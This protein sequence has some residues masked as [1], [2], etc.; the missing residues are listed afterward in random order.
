MEDK[1][2]SQEELLKLAEQAYEQTKEEELLS[3]VP[4]QE[5]PEEKEDEPSASANEPCTSEKPD[6][7]EPILSTNWLVSG[8]AMG[9]ILGAV[10]GFVLKAVPSFLLLGVITGTLVG[11]LLDK[12]KDKKNA[13][14]KETQKNDPS[15][16]EE[17]NHTTEENDHD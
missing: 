17:E 10:L 1:Q 11:L 15:I 9:L 14:F 6:D 4:T 3:S 13:A 5:Q 12:G 16:L 7:T 8:I 2:L